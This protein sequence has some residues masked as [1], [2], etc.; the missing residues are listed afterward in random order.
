[1]G[2]TR[3]Q[4]DNN[5][6]M[7]AGHEAS[8]STKRVSLFFS[9]DRTVRNASSLSTRSNGPECKKSLDQTVV[10]ILSFGHSNQRLKT[11]LLI[12]LDQ[13]LRSFL[14]WFEFTPPLTSSRSLKQT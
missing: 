14:T 1:M 9:L 10:M 6:S 4:R 11:L 13:R 7:E 3:R 5:V 2:G 8:V 12:L